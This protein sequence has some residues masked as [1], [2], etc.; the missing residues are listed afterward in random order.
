[1]SFTSSLHTKKASKFLHKKQREI[2]PPNLTR[3]PRNKMHLGL[4][5]PKKKKLDIANMVVFPTKQL[6]KKKQATNSFIVSQ[7]TLCASWKIPSQNCTEKTK[8]KVT[9]CVY[10]Y[11]Y[12]LH[13]HT[14]TYV[15]HCLDFSFVFSAPLSCLKKP[16]FRKPDVLRWEVGARLYWDLLTSGRYQPACTISKKWKNPSSDLRRKRTSVQAL[17]LYVHTYIQN[18]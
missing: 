18:T 12:T 14:Y 1:M 13:L 7:H 9:A 15:K 10:V 2:H 3:V 17:L 8:P 11:R 4:N 5:H 6:S 16:V